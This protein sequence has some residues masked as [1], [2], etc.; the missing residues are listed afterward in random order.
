M[1]KIYVSKVTNGY[2]LSIN[3]LPIS[4]YVAEGILEVSE[5][6]R[7]GRVQ[8]ALS[9]GMPLIRQMGQEALSQALHAEREHLERLA[10]QSME[11][12]QKAGTTLGTTLTQK[13]EALQSSILQLFGRDDSPIP[14]QIRAKVLSAI[15][16]LPEEYSK[17]LRAELQQVETRTAAQNKALLD[18]IES[19]E[20]ML[21]VQEAVKKEAN[22]G[23]NKG[24]VH[25]D[26]VNEC[27]NNFIKA[28]I[29]ADLTGRPVG[30]EKDRQG[31]TKGDYLISYQGRPLVVVEAKHQDH[32]RK[33]IQ[34]M[35]KL[36]ATYLDARGASFCIFAYASIEEAPESRYLFLDAKNRWASCVVDPTMDG[37]DFF[38]LSSLQIAVLLGQQFAS[39]LERHVPWDQLSSNVVQLTALMNEAVDGS[40]SIKHWLDQSVKVTSSGRDAFEAWIKQVDSIVQ[41]LGQLIKAELGQAQAS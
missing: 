29:S 4:N 35:A 21:A 23:T 22:R 11:Q 20:R 37:S 39:A 36:A 10:H 41:A 1:G 9:A 33:S 24:R 18:K 38:L 8:L 2:E 19:L 28:S 32:S 7:D 5:D 31:G 26:I 16:E 30:T 34:A 12:L 17:T 14:E 25:E 27:L 40:R 15:R 13:A 6:E 3:A